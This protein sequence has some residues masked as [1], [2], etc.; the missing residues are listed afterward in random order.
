MMKAGVDAN[1]IVA[2]PSSNVACQIVGEILFAN[3]A[4]S[5]FR[6]YRVR[7]Q[8][9][10]PFSSLSPTTR[11]LYKI[12]ISKLLLL[13]AQEHSVKKYFFKKQNTIRQYL[14]AV[15][16][17]VAIS[18]IGLSFYNL[19]GYRVVA[20][21]LLVAVSILAMS[22]DIV[23]VLVAATL[24]AL[25]WD[26]LF[27]PPRF[28]LTVGTPEDRLLLLMYFVIALINAVLTN[29]IRKMEKAIKEK[30]EKEKSVRFYNTLLNS[31]SHELRTPITTII[32][33]TDNL[34]SNGAQ[35][36]E[37]NKTELV[38]EVSVAAIR[39]NQQVENLLN[40]SR[41]ESGIFRI[42]KDWV[43]IS[44]I[45]YKTL[46]RLD[47]NLSKYRV[48]VE[49]PDQLPLFKLD[50]GLMEQ[51]IYNLLINVTQHTPEH[52]LITIQ[53]DC[54]KDRLILTIADNGSGFPEEEIDKVF[55]KFYRLTGS[56]TGG[57]G[58]GLSIVKGFVEAHGGTIQLKNLPVQGSKFTI[59][60]LTEKSYPHKI[61]D[62]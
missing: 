44:D 14:I 57:T 7:I 2:G 30:D 6:C 28:T 55:D 10:K 50:Y 48:A 8:L 22:L 17:V 26:F 45:I 13:I 41:L 29:K 54:V 49:I 36:S 53:A 33:S 37:E 51:V 18:L 47:Q 60:I 24:S 59:E 46:Q 61:K 56:K 5:D 39:L 58:L 27:I 32:G 19:V 35:L 1:G 62:E 21:M 42:K 9:Q 15:G 3:Q 11:N 38:N 52:T 23:P 4:Y 43:D 20:F 12:F 16:T 31:L 25:V 40:M 34:Q